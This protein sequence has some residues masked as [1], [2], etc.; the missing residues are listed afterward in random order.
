MIKLQGK[1]IEIDERF[2]ISFK[3]GLYTIIFVLHDGIN[4]IG[5]FTSFNTCYKAIDSIVGENK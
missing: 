4:K 1:T 3:E 2:S 5:E